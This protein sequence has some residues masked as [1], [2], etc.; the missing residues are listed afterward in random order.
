[1]TLNFAELKKRLQPRSVLA[2]TLEPG[3]VAA[4]VVRRENGAC[5]PPLSIPFGSEEV[6]K[7]PE[8]VGSELLLA[9]GAA[10]IRERR[11]VVCV[12]PAWALTASIDLPEV[13]AE[14]LRGYLELR[15]EREFSIPVSDLRFA[16]SSYVLPDGKRRATLAA[17][18]AK[19]MEALEKMLEAAGCRAL[20]ISLALDG[21][22]SG[23]NA[24]IHL[25]AGGDHVDVVV[26]AGGGVIGLRSLSGP[27]EAGGAAFDP[28]GFCRE[29]RI[30]LGRLPEAIRRQVLRARLGGSPAAA[31]TLCLQVRDRLLRMGIDC[32]PC[33]SASAAA[34]P[35]PAEGAAVECA[36]RFLGERPLAFEF[37]TPETSRVEEIFQ[38]FDSKRRRWMAV[39]AAAVF[40][41]LLLAV[42]IRSHMESS[43]T[44]EWDG[45]KRN[46][47]EV[48]ALQQKIRRF[49]PWF[50]PTPQ[51]L[52]VLES[53]VS[54]FPDGGDVWAKS[55]QIGEGYK[56]TCTGFA[57]D[58]AAWLG[59]LDRLRIRP[60]VTALQVQ[61]VRGANPVQFSV[62]YK[63]EPQHEG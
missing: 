41:L 58:Q 9:L 13:G 27:A 53:L 48:D 5:T 24:M 21:C 45:M 52:Q 61:Q 37:I 18:S 32:P 39:A 50:E 51:G 8:T 19:R 35:E 60:D 59:L 31:R 2:L 43:L 34:K 3:R 28:E 47:A 54:A 4:S 14:D 55:I 63:W 29:I 7:N 62:T 30:T 17:L 40:L 57:R 46:V 6:L 26:T 42:M 38:R 36:A 10:G 1:M 15:A 44:A 22:F 25:L 20:S 11:C 23:G 49:R 33:E 12:L 56:I 16:Y